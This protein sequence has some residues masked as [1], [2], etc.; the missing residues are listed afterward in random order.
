MCCRFTGMVVHNNI[1]NINFLRFLIFTSLNIYFLY[2]LIFTSLDIYFLHFL[3]FTSLYKP[4]NQ[5]TNYAIIQSIYQPST[6]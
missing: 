2:F 6:N 1:V 3:I 4:I 5:P